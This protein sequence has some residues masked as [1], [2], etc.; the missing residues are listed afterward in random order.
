MTHNCG[1]CP[2]CV[3]LFDESGYYGSVPDS[4]SETCKGCPH[5][6]E[7]MTE[8]YVAEAKRHISIEVDITIEH[9]LSLANEYDLQWEWV[10]EEYR[11]RLSRKVTKVV[12]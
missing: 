4:H 11:Y 7:G 10:L 1:G 8:K 3:V 9:L 6:E 5:R 12:A 2:E